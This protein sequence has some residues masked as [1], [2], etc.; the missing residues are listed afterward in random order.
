[1]AGIGGAYKSSGLEAPFVGRDRELRLVKELFHASAEERKGHLVSVV[2]I[3]GI[4]KSRLSWEFFKYLEGLAGITLWHRGRCLSYGEGVTYWALAEMVKMRCRIAEGENPASATAKLRAT[5]QQY[6]PDVEERGWVEPRLA[7]LLGLE[8]REAREKEDLFAAWRLFFERLAQASPT[9]MVFEDL[10]WADHALLDFVEYLLEWSRNHPLFVVALARPE[11]ADR[12]PGWGASRRNFTSLYL[13]P[14]SNEAMQVLLTGLVPGL[15]DEVRDQ[16]LARAEGVP[17]YAVETVRMLIDRGLL[18]QE[19]AEYRPTGPIGTIDVPE[20]LHALIAARLDGLTPD[21]RRVVQD[22]SV[23]GKTFSR[24]ALAGTMERPD[25]ELEPLLTA[26]VRKEVFGL[27]VDPRSPERGQYGF[28]QDLVK[29]VAYETLSKRD[30][31]ALHLAAAS[32]LEES[33]AGEEDEIVEIVASHYIQAYE[34][35]PDAP[36]AGHIKAQAGERLERAGR[37]AASLAA[38]NDAQRYFEQA[39]ALAGEPRDQAGLAEQAGEMARRAALNDQ[40]SAHFR[41]AIELFR[42]EGLESAAARVDARLAEVLWEEGKIEEGVARMEQAFSVLSGDR[43]DEDLATLA[44]QLA[45]MHYFAGHMEEAKA[46]IEVALELAESL[47]LP[48]VLSHALNTKSVIL[49]RTG[50]FEESIGLLVHALKIALD[51]DLHG[52]AIRAYINL[53]ATLSEGRNRYE[54]GLRYA[55]DGL[56]LSRKVGIRWQ[57]W[58]LL[59]HV[60]GHLTG[61]GRWD[62]A[63]SWAS[64]IPSAQD[65]PGAGFPMAWTLPALVQIAVGRGELERAKSLLEELLALPQAMADEQN[66]STTA[67][68]RAQVLRAEG[69]WQEAFDAATE[70]LAAKESAGAHLWSVQGGA[71]EAMEAALRMGETAKAEELL[72]EVGSW[73]G[74]DVSPFLRAQVARMSARLAAASGNSSD[75]EEGFGSAIAQFRK[76]DDPYSTAEPL[77]EL[78]EVLLT[79]GRVTDAEPLLAEAREIFERLGARPWLERIEAVEGNL[80]RVASQV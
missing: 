36:D 24:Q 67:L 56:A 35:L 30:R 6:L 79:Q 65:V 34:A 25:A 31:K 37:R 54:E 29:R 14:L 43:S 39:L 69:R 2:G 42:S 76:I 50:H 68:T 80:L 5:L 33:W 11:L 45:R 9:V 75:A 66:R 59:A 27:Q 53:S 64:E 1:V 47:E 3:G 19:G 40:A 70:A 23:L 38:N 22:A 7:H 52:A 13:E 18:V 21:E 20:T 15:S 17:L 32:Q 72:A 55:M 77:V 58:S 78:A 41:R 71:S 10:Q 63:I 60:V 61:L 49:G 16:I 26:L 4:G 73:P 12:A 74:L 62:E 48:L 46:R 57:E 44:A 28:L 51:N 8:D